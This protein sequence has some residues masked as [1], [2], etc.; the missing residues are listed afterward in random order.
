MKSHNNEYIHKWLNNYSLNTQNV[1]REM[2]KVWDEI[3][4]EKDINL[5]EKLNNFI[6]MK[7][8]T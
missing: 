4:S 5:N 3:F 1:W 8:G 7:F 6:A 2:D